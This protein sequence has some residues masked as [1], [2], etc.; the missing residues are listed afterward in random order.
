MPKKTTKDKPETVVLDASQWAKHLVDVATEE[1]LL[2]EGWVRRRTIFK[3]VPRED[4]GK[5][6]ETEE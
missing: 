2:P 6:Q 5:I 3:V 4:R 1:A